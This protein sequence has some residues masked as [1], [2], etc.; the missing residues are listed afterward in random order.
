MLMPYSSSFPA[1]PDW[2]RRY[3]RGRRGVV[4]A[5]YLGAGAGVGKGRARSREKAGL[6]EGVP[7][8]AAAVRL[9]A[10]RAAAAAVMRNRR[11]RAVR[12]DM[13]LLFPGGI[14]RETTGVRDVGR[15]GRSWGG[16]VE[17]KPGG[18]VNFG[19]GG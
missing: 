19:R 14:A 17:T 11:E 16:L 2:S 18:G 1:A 10:A 13:V 15:E 7:S 6:G 8:S 5:R 12:C 4:S 3:M 9:T